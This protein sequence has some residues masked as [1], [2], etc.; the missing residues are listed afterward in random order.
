VSDGSVDQYV[1]CSAE[2]F[3]LIEVSSISVRLLK[4]NHRFRFRLFGLKAVTAQ[5]KT[6]NKNP[7][8]VVTVH[9]CLSLTNHHLF[10]SL[11]FTLIKYY[12]C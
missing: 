7:M 2:R 5:N 1:M 9:Y 8:M 12:S 6:M 11:Y 4:N 3:V 10:T